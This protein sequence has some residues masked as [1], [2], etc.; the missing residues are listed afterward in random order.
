MKKTI[1]INNIDYQIIKMFIYN[2]CK[3]LQLK[4]SSKD[5]FSYLKIDSIT[6]KVIGEIVSDISAI[7]ELNTF[8]G[9]EK[10]ATKSDLKSDNLNYQNNEHSSESSRNMDNNIFSSVRNIKPGESIQSY[11]KYLD[12]YYKN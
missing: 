7:N 3:Y 4:D 5:Y 6:D 12:D 1:K 11:F 8:C 2:D 10:M 9:N